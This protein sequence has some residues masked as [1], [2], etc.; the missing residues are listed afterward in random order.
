MIRAGSEQ[1]LEVMKV[2]ITDGT[3]SIQERLNLLGTEQIHNICA[4]DMTDQ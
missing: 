3:D 4:N 1:K 2:C